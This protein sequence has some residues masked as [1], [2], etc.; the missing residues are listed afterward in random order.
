MIKKIINVNRT[1]FHETVGVLAMT[2]SVGHSQFKA[3]Y[4]TGPQTYVNTLNT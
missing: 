4:N 3:F 2:Y 1:L